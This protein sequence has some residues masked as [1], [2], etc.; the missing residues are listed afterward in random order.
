MKKI[1]T[2]FLALAPAMLS[3]QSELEAYLTP[4]IGYRSISVSANASPDFKD[5]LNE[6]DKVRQN[7]GGGRGLHTWI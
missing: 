4:G 2:L 3:A 6:M 7:W 5:S 1:L